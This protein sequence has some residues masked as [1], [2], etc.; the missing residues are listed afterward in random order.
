MRG[1]H[2]AVQEHGSWLQRERGGQ[3]IDDFP[4]PSFAEIGNALHDPLHASSNLFMAGIPLLM[5]TTQ[6]LTPKKYGSSL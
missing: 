6:W 2:F 3:G 4:A 5:V 1:I